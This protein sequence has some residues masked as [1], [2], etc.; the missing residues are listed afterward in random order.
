MVLMNKPHEA[1]L[2]DEFLR[3]S[4]C[5]NTAAVAQAVGLDHL[6][7][8]MEDAR[9]AILGADAFG[10]LD[11]E[12][13]EAPG[14]L[15]DGVY[16]LM[17]QALFEGLNERGRELLD[18]KAL[19]ILV[20]GRMMADLDAET[21]ALEVADDYLLLEATLGHAAAQ[22]G[23]TTALLP[24]ARQRQRDAEARKAKERDEQRRAREAE[25]RLEVAKGQEL[26]T[27]DSLRPWLDGDWNGVQ[28]RW[29]AG[30]NR[31]LDNLA[32]RIV[33]QARTLSDV[34]D[35]LADARP[36]LAQAADAQLQQ[37]QIA[38]TQVGRTFSDA[39][40]TAGS[41]ARNDRMLPAASSGHKPASYACADRRRLFDED[42]DGECYCPNCGVLL[43]D[44]SCLNTEDLDSLSVKP[45][46]TLLEVLLSN[47]L[48][49]AWRRQIG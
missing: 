6:Q 34:E 42:D 21:A 35:I 15:P 31:G 3:R 49:G 22:T 30:I 2:K 36:L 8:R 11:L 45:R 10:R 44:E 20:R 1:V 27:I 13:L 14:P 32:A 33:D 47:T 5:F 19:E 4:V 43:T 41:W 26:E 40:I 38:A 46:P 25:D 29:L 7:G 37:A 18:L 24:A 17:R 9:R 39:A 48:T 28:R 16:K 23:P 12:G